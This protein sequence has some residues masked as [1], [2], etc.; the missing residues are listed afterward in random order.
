MTMLAG[1]RVVAGPAGATLLLA[2]LVLGTLLL[3]W[4]P[5]AWAHASLKSS[6]P[7][8]NA[9]LAKSPSQILLTFT[10]PVD[11]SL[12]VVKVVDASGKP[13]AGVGAARSVAGQTAELSVPVRSPLAKGVYTVNWRSVSSVDGH[14]EVGAFAFGVGAVPKPGSLVTVSLQDSSPGLSA[15]GA[16]GRWMLYIGLALLVGAASTLL[17]VYRAQM[18]RGGLT[19]LRAAVAVAAVGLVVMIATER[20]VVGVQSLL[21]LFVTREGLYLV[22]LA[23]A[24]A[25]CG[26]AVFAVDIYPGRRSLIAVG[27]TAALA[28]FVHVLAGHADAPSAL[29]PFNV[30]LQWVHMT[31]IGVWTGGL[32]WLLLG[33]RG[34]DREER[35]AAVVAFSRV[36]TVTLVVVLAT[37][38]LRALV[39]IQPLS[40]L[41]ST[42]YGQTLLV[43]VGLVV[44]L[45]ALGALNHYRFVPALSRPGAATGGD[46]AAHHFGIDSRAELGIAVVVLAAT[47][48]LS[49]LAP[50]NVGA[51]GSSPP[52][53]QQTAVTGSD[54]ATTARVTLRVTP[55]TVG[56]NEYDVAVDAYDTGEP[57]PGVSAVTL[58]FAMPSK[59]E[60]NPSTLSL[61]RASDGTW[62]GKGLELSIVGTWSVTV[63][64]QEATGGVDVPLTLV[65]TR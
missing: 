16:V 59:P 21:P 57:L 19:L 56:S 39:E 34:R 60:V 62:Q 5:A 35:A 37:G 2:G 24:L 46:R 9:S 36:A 18:P 41:F 17:L 55:G 26:M 10:E 42:A 22:A 38:G 28:V 64:V 63:V 43:K 54:Y 44:A 4:A 53:T 48:V 65:V 3:A 14:V 51:S 50:A 32:V 1:R 12:S 31:A 15:A 49:G 27:A 30:F 47:A 45:V 23:L 33:L 40:N 7:A 13:A 6:D 20:I 58:D 61:R 29:Q 52:S 11:P 25:F 8:A